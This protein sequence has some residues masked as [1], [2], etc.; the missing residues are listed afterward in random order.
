MAKH[1]SMKV[2]SESGGG[3]KTEG[4]RWRGFS[5]SGN[6]PLPHGPLPC[7]KRE[8]EWV[9]FSLVTTPSLALNARWSGVL[10]L[11][12]HPLPCSKCEMEGVFFLW[13]QPLPRFK[14]KMEGVHFLWRQPPPSLQMQDGVSFCFLWQQPLPLLQTQDGVGFSFSR[15]T[16]SGDNPH[17][18]SKCKMERG[19]IF[20][21][22][23]P[24][25][26]SKR[27][28]EANLPPHS[29]CMQDGGGM[30]CCHRQEGFGGI[31]HAS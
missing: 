29:L 20:S 25:P 8:M 23:N 10:F 28:M 15:N 19:F 16:P 18:H 26:R 2:R 30:T 21:G 5:F 24:L 11:W 31:E 9:L 12:Q 3:T 22:D 1:K 6:N 14:C 17:P 13:Q 7:S 27:K 4:V